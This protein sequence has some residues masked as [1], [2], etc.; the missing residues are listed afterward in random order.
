MV[1]LLV[2]D[3]ARNVVVLMPDLSEQHALDLVTEWVLEGA[4]GSHL[5]VEV[6][7]HEPVLVPV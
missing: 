2:R 3:A 7:R 1:T 5:T 6:L 4:V